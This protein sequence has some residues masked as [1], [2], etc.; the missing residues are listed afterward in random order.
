[1]FVCL[2]ERVPVRDRKKGGGNLGMKEELGGR[3]AGEEKQGIVEKAEE[4]GYLSKIIVVGSV[5]L[6]S[7]RHPLLCL[8]K[9]KGK[10]VKCTSSFL[11]FPFFLIIFF[12]TFYYCNWS[13]PSLLIF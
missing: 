7:T 3:V 4:F 11:L 5:V 6:C 2:C 9:V 12:N 10:T 13:N 8:I 1:M